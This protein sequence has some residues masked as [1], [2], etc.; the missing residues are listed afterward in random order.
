MVVD[1]EGSVE[2]LEADDVDVAL[3]PGRELPGDCPPA[4]PAQ[5]DKLTAPQV[6]VTAAKAAVDALSLMLV[7]V[8]FSSSIV[9]PPRT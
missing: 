3:V 1:V 4:A 9:A 8:S 5:P 6:S 2:L 7:I